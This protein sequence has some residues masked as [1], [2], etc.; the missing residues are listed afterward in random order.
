MDDLRLVLWKEWRS[1]LRGQS[2]RQLVLIVATLEGG[3]AEAEGLREGDGIVTVDGRDVEGWTVDE[4]LEY[5]ALWNAAFIQSNDFVEATM[6]FLQRRPP[7]FT[8]E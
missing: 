1:F 2:R 8:G 3:P 5:V 6:A 7:E 4:H